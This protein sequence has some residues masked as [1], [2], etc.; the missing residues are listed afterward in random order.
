MR[1]AFDNFESSHDLCR[2]DCEYHTPSQLAHTIETKHNNELVLIHFNVRSLPKN[3]SKIELLLTQ[4]PTLPEIIAIF[5]TKLNSSN[6]HLVDIKNYNF[7]HSDSLTNA[8][9]VGIYIRKDL[10]YCINYNVSVDN[11]DCKSLFIEILN[12]FPNNKH[13]PRKNIIVGVILLHRHPR[14]SYSAFQDKLCNII[15]ETGR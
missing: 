12:K 3:K 4:M 15:H 5:E 2:G 9:G 14:Q 8:G 7:A 6:R 11:N 10:S 13:Q 1:T